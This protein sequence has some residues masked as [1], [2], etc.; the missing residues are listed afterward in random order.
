MANIRWLNPKIFD[1]DKLGMLEPIVRLLYIGLWCYADREGRLDDSPAKIRKTIL[2]YDNVTIQ[3]VNQMLD[4][5]QKQGFI[6]RYAVDDNNY[7]Q[8]V[9]FTKYQYPAINE[10]ESSIPCPEGYEPPVLQIKLDN[11]FGN[12]L[13]PKKQRK[14]L[15][16]EE[17]YHEEDE[18]PFTVFPLKDGTEFPVYVSLILEYQQTYP[19]MDIYAEVNKM[20]LWLDSN[21]AKRKTKTGIKRFMN[22]WI[23]RSSE[24]NGKKY[25]YSSGNQTMSDLSDWMNS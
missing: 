14:Q 23:S 13:K 15:K 7:I 8:V 25:S 24:R 12:E 4:E 1:N 16:I 11:F 5:I 20:K 22:S 19:D 9:N 2:G 10:P 17:D 3:Q 21:P 18:A 6:I